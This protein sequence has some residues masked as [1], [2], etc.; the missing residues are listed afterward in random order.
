MSR[1]LFFLKIFAILI[2]LTSCSNN[3]CD[4]GNLSLEENVKRS[5]LIAVGVVVEVGTN[6]IDDDYPVRSGLFKLNTHL[7]GNAETL[8]NYKFKR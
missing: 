1:F 3:K 5:Q 4:I 7:K 2:T 8:L 6:V